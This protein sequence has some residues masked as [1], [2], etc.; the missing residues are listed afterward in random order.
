MFESVVSA[1]FSTDG[2]PKSARMWPSTGNAGPTGW[3]E[4]SF[5]T[6]NLSCDTGFVEI[7]TSD[8]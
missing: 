1:H 8:E 5:A 3:P 7:C 4:T 2:N 6:S